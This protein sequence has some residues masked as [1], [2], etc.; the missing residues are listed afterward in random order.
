MVAHEPGHAKR[1]DVLHGTMVGAL[2]ALFGVI[3]LRL[4]IGSG[5]SADP[6]NTALLL[7]LIAVGTTVVVWRRT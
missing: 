1:N 3:L 6:R 7:A 5:F 2:A 4:L